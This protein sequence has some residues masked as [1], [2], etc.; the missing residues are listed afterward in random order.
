MNDPQMIGHY[1]IVKLLG[2]GAMGK[3][4]A[5]LDTFLEREV[6]IK[7]LRAELTQDPDFVG[8]F[9][10]EATSLAKL[11]HPNITTLY[12]PVL[13]GSDLYMV[14]ELVNGRPLDEILRERGKPLGVKESLAIIAQAA[15]GLAYAHQMGVIHRDIKPSNLMVADDGRIKIMDF[16]I[17]RVRGSVRLTR[18]GTAVG[19]PL[20]MSPEQCRGGEGDERSDLYSLAVVLYEMLAGAPPFSGA[21]EYDL[22]QAQIHAEAPPLVPRIS[23]VTPE[24]E[25][26][27]MTALA[28]RPEQR[29]PNMRAFSDA[30]GAT[31]L[32]IDASSIIRSA[33]HLVQDST[34]E[35]DVPTPEH[36]STKLVALA[37]SRSAT[38]VRRFKRLHPAA[39][40]ASLGIAAAALATLVFLALIEPSAPPRDERQ[41]RTDPGDGDQ[42]PI[43]RVNDAPITRGGDCN[44]QFATRNDPLGCNWR[45]PSSS[46][47]SASIS[48][49]RAAMKDRG[50]W[51]VAFPLAQKL[52]ESGDKE[53][54]YHLA[55]LY[56]K[57]PGRQNFS[58]A[59]NW[60]KKSAMQGYADAQASL[61]VMYK[62]GMTPDGR[63]DP[64]EA[65]RWF[66][67][68]EAQNNGRA[69]YWLGE[70]Y[71]KGLAGLD[72]SR[73]KA[74]ELYYKAS[75][76]DVPDAAEALQRLKR[77]RGRR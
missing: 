4:H 71:E 64:A 2:V 6:A 58:E 18:A 20:Y 16:G 13:Q 57:A 51:D 60:F 28:K 14:M 35:R 29:F 62:D 12:S 56:A 30:L 26:A 47:S 31:A 52:A 21:T 76:Q 40:G 46:N 9:R 38:L 32:R 68:A 25:S 75:L 72:V 65:V 50:R 37:K 59:F 44:S 7:S 3:V 36:M 69:Q 24:I 33:G 66:E 34:A 54:Q 45:Q 43:S 42:R 77:R 70:A 19:T 49:L 8:R 10:A 39:Q 74:E 41:T 53:A 15:D 27:I 11:N 55:T 48:E 17:A 5:A 23:G 61:G 73:S 67:Q 22:T 63:Q 1:R